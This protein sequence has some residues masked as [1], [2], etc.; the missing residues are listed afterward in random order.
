MPVRQQK[1]VTYFGEHPTTVQ[2][3]KY[4]AIDLAPEAYVQQAIWFSRTHSAWR[5]QL[6]RSL[7]HTMPGNA[8]AV[9]QRASSN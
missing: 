1:E 9:F 8:I 7:S 4:G 3:W 6:R 2:N 5:R